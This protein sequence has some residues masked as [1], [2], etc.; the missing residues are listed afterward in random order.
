MQHETKHDLEAV[1]KELDD[2][3]TRCLKNLSH[4][5][6]ISQGSGPLPRHKRQWRILGFQKKLK[7]RVERCQ[8]V[9]YPQ[10]KFNV[11]C[12]TNQA[13]RRPYFYEIM[14][15]QIILVGV[16]RLSVYFV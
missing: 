6:T 16:W 9:W 3:L 14:L 4:K 8:M 12:V 7:K 5:Q 13:K 10:F 15:S 2:E 1:W 11:E